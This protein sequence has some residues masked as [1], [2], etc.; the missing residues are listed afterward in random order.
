LFPTRLLFLGATLR[1]NDLDQLCLERLQSLAHGNIGGIVD[2]PRAC[3]G[4][5]TNERRIAMPF[6]IPQI[7]SRARK[8]M[9]QGEI[10]G[11]ARSAA[12][13]RYAVAIRRLVHVELDINISERRAQQRQLM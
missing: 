5:E 6:Q 8:M 12:V 2:D 1:V 11:D 7:P 10:G 9:K 4:R 13:K 3:A